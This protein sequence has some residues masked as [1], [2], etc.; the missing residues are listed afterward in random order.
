MSIKEDNSSS[1]WIIGTIP[2]PIPKKVVKKM[3]KLKT[4]PS[5][6]KESVT[7]FADASGPS[8]SDYV[9]ELSPTQISTVRKKKMSK[10][11]KKY[12]HKIVEAMSVCPYCNNTGVMKKFG[13]N[14]L[15]THCS[16]GEDK[17]VEQK[18]L[19][20]QQAKDMLS[21]GMTTPVAESTQPFHH[22]EVITSIEDIEP[23]LEAYKPSDKLV[24]R[25]K[26]LVQPKLSK[27]LQDR[28]AARRAAPKNSKGYTPS[29]GT[30]G[31]A[32]ARRAQMSHSKKTEMDEAY[33]KDAVDKAIASSNRSGKK[34]GGKE[35]K[36]IHALLK[37]RY[38]AAVQSPEMAA[39]SKKPMMGSSNDNRI[40]EEAIFERTSN[41]LKKVTG[42]G[43]KMKRKYLGKMRGRTETGKPAHAIEIDPVVK[44][45]RDVNKTVR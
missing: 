24:S 39:L 38:S 36:R 10:V 29:A 14:I 25:T 9:A 11:R 43:A 8:N 4:T 45:T 22:S 5:V 41:E 7:G 6:N 35:A 15:C 37:G 27:M 18:N 42:D 20:F 40:S 26:Y 3:S 12:N 34:I 30:L 28:L 23:I 16:A 21:R 19:M 31:L 2:D 13:N 44:V 1:G 33:S 17:R 32:A